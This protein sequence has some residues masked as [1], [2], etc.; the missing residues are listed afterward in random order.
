[1]MHEIMQFIS[2]HPILILIWIVLLS[3]VM[4]LTY[5][6][7]FAKTKIITRTQAIQ[8]INKAEAIIIDLRSLDDFCKGH[9]INSMHL[10][11]S[12][13]QN[14]NVRKLEKYKK[15]PIIVVSKNGIEATNHAQQLVQYGFEHIFILQEGI[16][17]WS[18]ANLPL[19]CSKK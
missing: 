7:L 14:N 18:N 12:E 4:I 3:V 13:I 2:R 5:Q 1:M 6:D 17:G 9:I 16:V 19:A 11:P 10:T 8:L 15:Y